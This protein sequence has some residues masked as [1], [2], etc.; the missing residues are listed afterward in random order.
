LYGIK[1]SGAIKALVFNNKILALR[2][3]FIG[4]LSPSNFRSPFN[5]LL[6]LKFPELKSIFAWN[7]SSFY[8]EDISRGQ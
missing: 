5:F 3:S 6:S 4:F 7:K 2:I 1:K 8:V